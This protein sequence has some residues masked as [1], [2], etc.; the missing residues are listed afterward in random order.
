LIRFGL[1]PGLLLPWPFFKPLTMKQADYIQNITNAERRFYS[2]DIRSNANSRSIRGYAAVFNS[3]SKNLGFFIERLAPG[4]FDDVL[5]DDVVALF[6]HNPDYPL[7]RN[8]S[9]LKIGVDST[10]LWYEFE[11]PDTTIGNDLLSNVRA[12]IIKQSSFAF[13]VKDEKWDERKGQP[14]L[15]TILKVQTLYDV[16]PVTY[17]AYPDTSVA[18]RHYQAKKRLP[19][20]VFEK[21]IQLMKF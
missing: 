1:G 13:T 15:R 7:A 2:A 3:D 5:Q 10:G 14:S 6:N 9:T 20:S 19:L 18:S 17:P 21:Q 16:S 11:A 12:G 8:G 4:A